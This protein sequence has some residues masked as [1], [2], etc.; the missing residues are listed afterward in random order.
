MVVSQAIQVV[1]FTA[2]LFEFFLALGIVA[3]P[4]DVTILWSAEE[5]C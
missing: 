3:V 5:T 1:F 4:N 2:G